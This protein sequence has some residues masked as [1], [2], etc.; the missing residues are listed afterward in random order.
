MDVRIVRCSTDENILQAIINDV[1]SHRE[2]T[3]YAALFIGLDVKAKNHYVVRCETFSDTRKE[4]DD[5]RR[6][7]GELLRRSHGGEPQTETP[8]VL[9]SVS[10]DE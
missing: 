10:P 6:H 9:L 4:P 7:V 1:Y 5:I 8:Y 3:E 2:D